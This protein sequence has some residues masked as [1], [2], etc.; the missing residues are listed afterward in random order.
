MELPKPYLSYSAA[1]L[2]WK[3]KQ[4][5]RDV[6]YLNKP[7]VDTAYTIFGKELSEKLQ[8][9]DP[10]YEGV[11]RF[12]TYEERIELE[13]DGVRVLSY[14]DCFDLGTKAFIE[15][16]TS[17]R[18]KDGTHK[19]TQSVVQ[20]HEQLPWYSLMVKEKYG[21]VQNK[22]RLVYMETQWQTVG[23][24]IG[25]TMSLGYT[26]NF[27]IFDRTIAEWERKRMREKIVRTAQEISE[28][29]RLWKQNN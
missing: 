14:L 23:Q 22:C 11:P 1:S 2:W 13:I 27:T 17:I 29:Y 28:D 26:G 20:A 12:D 21:R 9:N 18:N 19:W 6:Y 10:M 3:N 7:K 4:E 8:A 15:H 24:G 16:K 5:F 25:Q